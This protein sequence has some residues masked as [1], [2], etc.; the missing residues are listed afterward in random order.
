MESR[1]RV[2]ALI[3]MPGAGKSA[4]GRILAGLLGRPAVDLDELIENTTG[5]TPAEIFARDGEAAFRQLE[6]QLLRSLVD[7]GTEC[8][9]ACGG[10][11]VT[12]EASRHLLATACDAVWLEADTDTLLERVR[13]SGTVRPLLEGDPRAA[14]VRL[15]AERGGWYS[16]VSRRAIDTTGSS[17]AE[18]A[19]TLEHELRAG[20]DQL[21]ATADERVPGAPS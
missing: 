8:V 1:H 16:E 6:Y 20:A 13:Q 11:V 19:E 3:G 10:G 17:A 15:R 9:V 7:S 14:L 2:V 18:V 21:R 5:S 12:E 4:V